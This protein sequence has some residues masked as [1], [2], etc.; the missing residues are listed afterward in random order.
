MS[1]A[2]RFF[3]AVLPI[4]CAVLAGVLAFYGIEGWG[5]FLLAS[6]LLGMDAAS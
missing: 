4:I 2:T 1:I 6:I 5:W 3:P